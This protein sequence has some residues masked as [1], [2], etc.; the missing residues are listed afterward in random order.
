MS[1]SNLNKKIYSAFIIVNWNWQV[2]N[3]KDNLLYVVGHF[4][5]E[6]KAKNELNKS[7]ELLRTSNPFIANIMD[8][9]LSG[10][11]V[12]IETHI[13]LTEVCMNGEFRDPINVYT[14]KGYKGLTNNRSLLKQLEEKT[15]RKGEIVI[16]DT[17]I[18]SSEKAENLSN[19]M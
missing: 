11:T 2:Q 4:T 10:F 19:W 1:S 8:Y 16:L 17:N 3:C 13:K 7:K 15:N 18:F 5:S 14:I 9:L 12:K 6:E